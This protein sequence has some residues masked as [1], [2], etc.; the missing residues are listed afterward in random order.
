[1][2]KKGGGKGRGRERERERERERL[3]SGLKLQVPRE[4]KNGSLSLRKCATVPKKAKKG[5]PHGLHL[6]T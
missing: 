3:G 4:P 2:S 1:M 6:P 5:T